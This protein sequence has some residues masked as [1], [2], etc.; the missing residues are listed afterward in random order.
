MIKLR[1]L[2]LVHIWKD[3][4]SSCNTNTFGGGMIPITKSWFYTWEFPCYSTPTNCTNCSYP[5]SRQ[6][7]IH[8]IQYNGKLWPTQLYTLPVP[9]QHLMSRRLQQR[10]RQNNCKFNQYL[11]RSNISYAPY[12]PHPRNSRNI[13]VE[14]FSSTFLR[15]LFNQPPS[16]EKA[17]YVSSLVSNHGWAPA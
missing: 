6:H 11:T 12:L 17:K 15:C 7:T 1:E 13:S 5:R 2:Y 8:K 4:K 10:E 16:L 14:E 3:N 9:C